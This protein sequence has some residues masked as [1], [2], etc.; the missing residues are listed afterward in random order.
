[1][2]MKVSELKEL[3]VSVLSS[4]YYSVEEA[5]KIADVYLFAEVTGKNTQGIV[6]LMGK[7]PSQ[8]IKPEYAPKI[9]KKTP[10]S[11]V[12]DAGGAT[13][14]L[15]A[16]IAVDVLIH[17]AKKTGFGVVALNNTFSSTGALSYYAKKVAENNLIGIIAA[18]SPRSV[19][20]A[21][22][23]EPVF[24]TN[25][26]A[27]GF[28]TLEQPVV[29]DMATSAMTFY[30]LVRAKALG[31]PIPEGI[32]I[33]KDGHPTTDP[34]AAMDGALLSFD[35]SYKG[36]GLGLMVEL[37]TGPLTG[38]QYVFSDGDWGTFFLAFSPNL[39]TEVDV[40][41]QKASDLVQ[42]VKQA[43]THTGTPVHIPGYDTLEKA[44][45][46][47]KNNGIIEIEDSIIEK[48]RTTA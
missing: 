31:Q 29:F 35:R 34:Q 24:G 30:G 20:F 7:E 18:G 5:T 28:P 22:G 15:G 8:D 45:N 33:D 21:G 25:P 3:I 27:F 44:E 38:A 2:K 4:K 17:K 11:A 23:I 39:L 19:A 46:L 1:M 26:I 16:Q 43:K 9:I 10:V 6:K 40:F 36:S 47:I 14:P 42:K 13:G 32:A 41:K 37:L 48:L 12:V